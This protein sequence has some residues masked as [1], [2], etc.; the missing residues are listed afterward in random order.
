MPESYSPAR[1]KALN[2][3][4]KLVRLEEELFLTRLIPERLVWCIQLA[5][6]LSSLTYFYWDIHTV[7]MGIR[8]IQQLDP[9][10]VT[11]AIAASKSDTLDAEHDTARAIR[12]G[13]WRLHRI[14]QFLYSALDIDWEDT[15]QIMRCGGLLHDCVRTHCLIAGARDR[16]LE[17]DSITSDDRE[18]MYLTGYLG[19]WFTPFRSLSEL[20]VMLLPNGAPAPLSE[21]RASEDALTW[22]TVRGAALSLAGDVEHL[23]DTAMTEDT[24]GVIDTVQAIRSHAQTL[25]Q[26]YVESSGA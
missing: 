11:R 26:L 23:M 7:A 10:E 4:L 17:K 1:Q 22:A 20:I 24:R 14:L 6:H 12:T 9:N 15:R 18:A 21:E 3:R 2:A 8:G 13:K 19:Y 5:S 16:L 25:A